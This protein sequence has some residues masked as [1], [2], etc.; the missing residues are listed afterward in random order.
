MAAMTSKLDWQ[1]ILYVRIRLSIIQINGYIPQ[2]HVL[3]KRV[4]NA[5]NRTKTQ[6]D[7]H[8]FTLYKI[9]L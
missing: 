3:R 5:Y 4:S 1:N 6:A 8:I 7:N 2:V 9:A